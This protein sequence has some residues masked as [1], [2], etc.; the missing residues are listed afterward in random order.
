MLLVG[1]VYWFA[2]LRPR[3]AT[4][5]QLS[6]PADQSAAVAEHPLPA[7]A[8]VPTAAAGTARTTENS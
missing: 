2:Y 8:P 7:T 1:L 3:T 4:H 6:L 5:W